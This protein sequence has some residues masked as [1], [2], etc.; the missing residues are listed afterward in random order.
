MH[1]IYVL[2]CEDGHI[3]VG[4]TQQLNQR[5]YS[6]ILKNSVHTSIYRPHSLIG[7]YRADVNSAF[8]E[9]HRFIQLPHT[10]YHPLL[11]S[12]WEEH[13]Y[14]FLEVE[15]LITERYMY[16]KKEDWWKVRGGKYTKVLTDPGEICLPWKA[17]YFYHK[18]K[19]KVILD[20]PVCHC[21]YPCEVAKTDKQLVYFKCPLNFN[22][23]QWWDS[24]IPIT[25]PEPCNFWR[26]YEGDVKKRMVY[27]AKEELYQE[28]ILQDWVKF[29]PRLP[30][31]QPIEQIYSCIQCKKM[32]YSPIFKNGYRR[33]CRPCFIKHYEDL[34]HKFI[35]EPKYRCISDEEEKNESIEGK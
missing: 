20:R 29:L 25:V 12:D 21:G 30:E 16:E 32:K 5:L 23:Q 2:A 6:H 8:T 7:L 17:Q 3:Y 11:F 15:N 27:L 31:K 22:K 18:L 13:T 4:Q 26:K 34:R 10:N 19:H 33:I 1:W 35:T 24:T 14:R 9:Y 28:Y